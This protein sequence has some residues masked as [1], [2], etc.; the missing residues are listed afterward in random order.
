MN[1]KLLN[2]LS[3][4]LVEQEDDNWLEKEFQPPYRGSEQEEG[5]EEG[6]DYGKMIKHLR[7]FFGYLQSTGVNIAQYVNL[8]ETKGI[9][10]GDSTFNEFVQGMKY[11]G[12]DPNTRTTDGRVKVMK[13]DD[14]IYLLLINYLHNGGDRRNFKNGDINLIP[15]TK[16]NID[17][18]SK[19]KIIELATLYAEVYGNSS[20]KAKDAVMNNPDNFEVDRE[21]YDHEYDDGIKFDMEITEVDR[22]VIELKP[23]IFNLTGPSPQPTDNYL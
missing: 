16:W 23:N 13:N 18:D 21:T 19:E 15:G 4:T 2:I 10:Y 8:M 5:S 22:V 17:V 6:D 7:L 3:S 12:L 11:V 9:S 20:E 1:L 14:T